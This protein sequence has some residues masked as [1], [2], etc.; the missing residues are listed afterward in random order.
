MVLTSQQRKRVAWLIDGHLADDYDEAT[1][2]A[3]WEREFAG[4]SSPQELFLLAAGSHPDQGPGEW[5][6]FLDS[7]LCDLGT[8]LLVF[9]RNSPVY[10]YGDEP[11]GGWEPDRGRYELM[12]EIE[13]RYAA[14]RYPS[15]VVQFDPASF[16]GASFLA[17]HSAEDLAR[18]PAHMRRPS[19][20]E[21]V[22]PLAA[23]DFDWSNGFRGIDSSVAR[24]MAEP[25][26]GG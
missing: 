12:R 9:W 10:F 6:Q 3:R 21:P 23:E 2:E 7:P 5:R 25:A 19:P 22:P 4:L 15:A 18:V 16:Q 20:G 11:A 8:A 1:F 26:A 24:G 17:G 14:G 13:R